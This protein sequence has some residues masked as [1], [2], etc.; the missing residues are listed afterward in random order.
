MSMGF[1]VKLGRLCSS[2]VEPQ[3]LA[4][5]LKTRR[6]DAIDISRAECIARMKANAMKELDL[7]GRDHEEYKLQLEKQKAIELAAI[8]AQQSIAESQALVL[9]EALKTAKIDIVGGD[10]QFFDQIANA[11]KGG[12]ATSYLRR[13]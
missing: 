3:R 12:K 11:V 9:G 10:G 5:W 2:V 4:R 13:T 7:V 6:H 8:T 1:G